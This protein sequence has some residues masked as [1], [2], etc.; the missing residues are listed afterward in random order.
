MHPRFPVLSLA[1]AGVF[2]LTS[3]TTSAADSASDTSELLKRLDEQ[4]AQIDALKKQVKDAAA[5][6][7][8]DS[9]AGDSDTWLGGYGELH[10]SN[11]EQKTAEFDLHRFVLF[12][13]HKFDEKLRFFSELEVEHSLAGE[14]KK[15]EVE[16][17]Q[18]YLEYQVSDHFNWKTGLFLVPVGILNET[19]EP[20]TFYGVER[21]KIESDIVPSTWWEAGAGASW[22]FAEGF[23]LD[24][25]ATSG[26]KVGSDFKIRSGRQKVSEAVGEDLAYT[27]RIRYVGVPGLQLAASLQFQQDITQGLQAE[28]AEATLLEVHGIYSNG[29]FSL[30]AL[31]AGWDIDSDAAT[32]IGRDEQ[33]GW[34]LEPSWRFNDSIGVF[35]RHSTWDTEA[36][37]SADSE[38]ESLQFGVNYWLHPQVVLKAD[39]ERQDGHKDDAGAVFDDEGVNFGVGYQF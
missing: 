28:G 38:R 35:V 32:A 34:Y 13:G 15:G 10:H 19:H 36:G 37:S 14:G 11:Y 9:G 21:N 30:R 12:I 27:G 6:G 31:Y 23:T 26:L 39:Y 24:V 22:K 1:L 3:T 17:E 16:L 4:Q 2:A 33:T 18:A 25:A 5:A 29:P 20:P 7:E 8:Q